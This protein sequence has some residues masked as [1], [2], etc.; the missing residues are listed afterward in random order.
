MTQ[1]GIQEEGGGGEGGKDSPLPDL[2]KFN[3]LWT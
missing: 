2:K 3:L 1:A